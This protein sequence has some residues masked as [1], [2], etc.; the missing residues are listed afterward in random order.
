MQGKLIRLKRLFR[1]GK[2][3]IAALDHGRRH[4]PIQGIE[5]LGCT[6]DRIVGAGVDAVM[7]TPA[8]IQRYWDKITDAY[9]VARIDGTG[10]VKSLDES[11][12]RLISSVARA[13]GSGADAV[14]VMIYPGSVNESALWEKL[15]IVVD[16]AE[17]LGVPVMAEVVPKPPVF[18]D[19]YSREAVAYGARIA[20]EI[21]ADIVKAPFTAGYSEVVKA[22]PVP[23][24]VLGGAKTETPLDTLR[25]V[26]EAVKAGAA[27]AAIGRNIFQ[28]KSPE[29][30]VKAL[31]DI[32]HKGISAEEA[33]RRY[34]GEEK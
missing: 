19:K 17:A 3:L 8:M 31:M 10:T 5:D 33:Y 18:K 32:I 23:L 26:E 16:E 34:L 22:V 7:M 9:I 12:D 13:V 6:L 14:S 15:A 28:H 29:A 4:G 27:G 30:M 21:G 20:A 11:D 24:V 25:M 1:D 2:A